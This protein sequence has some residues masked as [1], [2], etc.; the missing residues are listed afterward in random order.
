[1]SDRRSSR[2]LTPE[3]CSR[4]LQGYSLDFVPDRFEDPDSISRRRRRRSN[5]S[6][7]RVSPRSQ[8]TGL[9]ALGF[10]E[11]QRFE[12]SGSRRSRTPGV[13]ASGHRLQSSRP[14]ASEG[15]G[16][17]RSRSSGTYSSAVSSRAS[18]GTRFRRSRSRSSCRSR[19]S[20]LIP[21][22]E[23]RVER[24]E[25]SSTEVAHS[26]NIDEAQSSSEA[27]VDHRLGAQGRSEDVQDT[28]RS[29]CQAPP[30][31]RRSLTHGSEAGD[32]VRSEEHNAR[33]TVQEDGAEVSIRPEGHE[34]ASPEECGICCERITE[35]LSEALYPVRMRCCGNRLHL[36]CAANWGRN[37]SIEACL[38]CRHPMTDP[39]LEQ[40]FQ[41]L[42]GEQGVAFIG[43]DTQDLD[44]QTSNTFVV[45]DYT[46]RYFVQGEAREPEEPID[47]RMLCCHRIGPP[48]DFVRLPERN[49]KWSP[50]AR[51]DTRLL[52]NGQRRVS[53][54]HSQWICMGC[55]SE[56][57]LETALAT[58]PAGQQQCAACGRAPIWEFDTHR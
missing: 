34:A 4:R 22:S 35:G 3:I 10:R 29:L 5:T 44:N 15:S 50:V 8:S 6:L 13:T 30:S 23:A 27:Q 26:D 53:R 38:Y 45:H 25:D 43:S 28:Q 12:G 21:D 7:G 57:S 36:A 48:P 9:L 16:R 18:V 56:V 17:S 40:E 11:V 24:A 47:L 33:A 55:S 32:N 19:G 46:D 1:M 58:R 2:T 54:W 39:R 14:P 20:S 42:C 52:D 31:P 41:D 49:M 37:T 51:Y